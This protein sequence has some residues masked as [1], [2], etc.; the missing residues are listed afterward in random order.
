LHPKHIFPALAAEE[1]FTHCTPQNKRLHPCS[2]SINQKRFTIQLSVVIF[3]NEFKKCLSEAARS[4]GSNSKNLVHGRRKRPRV[5][6]GFVDGQRM[7][8]GRRVILRDGTVGKIQK[9]MRGRATVLIYDTNG[10][11]RNIV[12]DTLLLTLWKSQAAVLLGQQKLCVKEVPSARKVA[13]VRANG[14]LP[15]K[16]GRRKRGRPRKGVRPI[17]Q[18]VV[19]AIRLRNYMSLDK[20]INLGIRQEA[21]VQLAV[22]RAAKKDAE[23]G[24][25]E[26]IRSAL[27]AQY[28]G[29]SKV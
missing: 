23:T 29:A 21:E 25:R 12:V 16:P 5:W 10:T 9:V 2:N 22:E 13:A 20:M 1:A 8:L 18:Y 3:M 26:V 27:L 14:K 7:W 24:R 15:V 28:I 4:L 17:H 11:P 19:T 6:T